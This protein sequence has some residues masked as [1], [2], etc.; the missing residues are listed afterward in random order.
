MLVPFSLPPGIAIKG[1]P[2]ETKGR[3][4][5][6]NFVRWKEGAIQPIGWWT[7]VTSEPLP[8]RINGLRPLRDLTLRQWLVIGTNEGVWTLGDSRLVNRT[9]S[10]F[11]PGKRITE[12]GDGFG[13]RWYSLDEYG[14]P[15][16]GDTGLSLEADWWSMDTWGEFVVA[17]SVRDGRVL[18]WKPGDFDTPADETFAPIPG[19]PVDN[20]A[21]LV[22]DERHLML[23][24]ADGDPRKVKWSS[25]EDYS[26]WTPTAL[27][28]AGELTL[29][30]TGTLQM[31]AKTA[32]EILVLSETDAFRLRYVGQPYG[33]GQERVGVNCGVVGPRAGTSTHD[34]VAWMGAGG[35]WLYNGQLQQIPCEVW[36]YVFPDINRFQ[37]NQVTCGHNPGFSEIWWF[38]PK[39]ES[40]T[41]C[42]YV[43]WNYQENWWTV[44]RLPRSEWSDIPIWGSPLAGGQDGHVYQHEMAFGSPGLAR[45][46]KPFVESSP[47]EVA[48]GDRVAHVTRLLPDHSSAELEALSYRFSARMAPLT[49]S[50]SFGPYQHGPEGWADTRFAGREIR[51]R[52]T[53]E[54]DEDWRLGPLRAEI[55]AGGKR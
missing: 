45:R 24:A 30:T 13:S 33:Y 27:N 18:L 47:F 31:A 52:V 42:H 2:L 36:D 11:I 9:P 1:T 32:G 16:P 51:W 15:R 38:F 23:L 41:N 54:R 3:W 22:T 35:F 12:K 28:L 7:R 14:T 48:G 26:D 53:A 49:A 10:D 34:F 44:G 39:G 55:V 17:C 19:A 20:R 40:E 5:D 50:N 8:G 6:A 21:L 4:R 29:N 37:I 46:D 25:R 43:A